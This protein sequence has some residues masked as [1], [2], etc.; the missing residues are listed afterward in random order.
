MIFVLQQVVHM[1]E[2]RN[3]YRVLVGRLEGKRPFVRPVH[4]WEVNIK[5]DLKFDPWRQF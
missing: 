4:G 5:L 1:G 3:E 2:K